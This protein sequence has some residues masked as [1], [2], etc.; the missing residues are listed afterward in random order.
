[1]VIAYELRAQLL[2]EHAQRKLAR[3][4]RKYR[5]ASYANQPKVRTSKI[6]YDDTLWVL[7]GKTPSPMIC[8]SFFQDVERRDG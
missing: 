7:E 8:L 6:E 5:S 4:D 2:K 3:F 1:M